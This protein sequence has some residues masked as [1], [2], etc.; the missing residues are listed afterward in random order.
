MPRLEKAGGWQGWSD[1]K[2]Y[3]RE[4]PITA[5]SVGS[6]L[7]DA[8]DRYSYSSA[9]G[10]MPPRAV[11]STSACGTNVCAV[12]VKSCV[13]PVCGHSLSS[14]WVLNTALSVVTLTP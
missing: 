14:H 10:Y 7:S 5:L 12:N 6:T 9:E 4:F 8:I 2:R 3:S 11:S 13:A 1:Q